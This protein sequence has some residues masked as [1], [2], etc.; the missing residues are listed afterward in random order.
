MIDTD[1]P[2][3]FLRP[4]LAADCGWVALDWHAGDPL[5][6]K[7]IDLKRYF[8]ESGA[9]PLASMLPLVTPIDP[10]Y[11][12]DNTFLDGFDNRQVVFVLPASCAENEAVLD[13][14]KEIHTKGKHIGLR[15]DRANLLHHVPLA[16]FDTLCLDAAFAR[17]ELSAADLT[18]AKD[19]GFRK[20][21]TP[22]NSHEMFGWLS[23]QGFDWY[24]SQFLT[25]RKHPS[26]VE[27]D[28]T[29]LKLLKLF[30][31]VH[32]DG[33]TR[34][35]EGIFREE[36]KLSYNL[37]RLVNSAAVGARSTISN[38]GQAIAL[39]G[40]RQLQRWL[41]LLIYAN[42]LSDGN[43]PN[44]LMQLAAARG[45]QMELLSAEID[46]PPGLPELTDNAFMT[47]LF[48]LL[49]ILINMPMSEILAELPLHSEVEDALSSPDDDGI[50]G[51]LLSGVIAG[52][53]GDYAKA[54]SIFSCLGI[55]AAAH[56]K[57]QVAALYWACRINIENAG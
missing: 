30:N 4:L 39:L 22:V 1:R 3:F 25:K 20:I 31:L 32:Q 10:E 5:T 45:R 19:A 24:D 42:N 53:S 17:Q 33:D 23:G 9:A 34:E 18:Y 44:P 50:L 26:G 35:I 51:Q 2:Y 27:P 15:L 11:L 38:F 41:Q 16:A 46:P 8:I 43:A 13:R 47:G 48:S 55:S 12:E 7:S 28:M 6:T 57:S 54:A 21:A 52:E 14:C 29:R 49:D 40:R 56:A 36:P 37:L